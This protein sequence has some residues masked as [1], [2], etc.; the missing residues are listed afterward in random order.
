MHFAKF[1]TWSEVLEWKGLLWYWA[2]MDFRPVL[3]SVKRRGQGQKLRVD[4]GTQAD[5][6]WAESGHLDRFRREKVEADWT[7]GEIP[8]F[9]AMLDEASKHGIPIA[10][11]RD[12]YVHDRAALI[13]AFGKIDRLGWILTETCTFIAILGPREAFKKPREVSDWDPP[14]HFYIGEVGNLREVSREDWIDLM[15]RLT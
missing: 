9:A 13:R 14:V 12:L 1:S 4:A 8:F 3:V 2:P 5:P 7:V 15:A 6:F 11:T 10:Y